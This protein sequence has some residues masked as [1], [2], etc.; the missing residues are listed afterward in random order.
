MSVK[1]R[2]IYGVEVSFKEI[3]TYY[4]I[5]ID[6]VDALHHD[7]VLTSYGD[8]YEDG[9]QLGLSDDDSHVFIAGDFTCGK[10]KY[11]IMAHIEDKH[12]NMNVEHMENIK[13]KS[14]E[15]LN[16]EADYI[17]TETKGD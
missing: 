14:K 2:R 3:A 7:D 12:G 15:L 13:S 4:G 10:C 16:K 1:N 9:E 6:E 11:Y 8:V 5:S 17:I